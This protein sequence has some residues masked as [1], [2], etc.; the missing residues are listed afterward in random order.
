MNNFSNLPLVSYA[1]TVQETFLNF[2]KFVLIC[3]LLSLGILVSFASCDACCFERLM[4]SLSLVSARILSFWSIFNRIIPI[5]C[6]IELKPSL[7]MQTTKKVAICTVFFQQCKC[8]VANV[9]TNQ[10]KLPLLFCVYEN[11]KK[12]HN[13]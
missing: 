6:K 11:T 4:R 10:F 7:K 1:R 2:K 12:T 5:I 3:F 9:Q 8:F 13:H